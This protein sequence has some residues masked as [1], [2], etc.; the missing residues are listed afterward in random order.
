MIQK[1]DGASLYFT[2]DIANLL[3]RIK[4]FRP[5]KIIYVVGNEQALHFQQLFATAK[6]LGLESSELVHV[7]YGLVLGEDNK[8]F[9]T[10]EGRAVLL[11][12]VLKKVIAMAYKIVDSKNPDLSESE[13]KKRAKVI[14]VGALKY[15]D[16]HQNRSTDIT[17]NWDKMLNLSGDS[18]PY[19]QY[20]YARISSIK[21]KAGKISKSSGKFLE[22]QSEIQIIRKVLGFPSMV[23]TSA[24][25]YLPNVLA[26]YL[27]ELANLV[28]SYYESTPILNDDNRN[29]K[30]DR[31]M[32][33]EITRTVLRKGLNLLGIET[34]ER[35]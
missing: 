9:A 7:K 5:Q 28:N 12:D 11:E 30:S 22:S 33:M 13:K 14:G 23:L 3:Y 2:R 6:I 21:R 29:R 25:E 4:K 10:R 17:F 32:L 1:S 18:G 31:L 24:K 16:L 20:T 34:L 35:I 27:Y 26:L 15:N 8:K 19:L